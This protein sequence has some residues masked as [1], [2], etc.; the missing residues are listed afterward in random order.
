[1]SLFS[2]D[3]EDEEGEDDDDDDDDS[4]DETAQ[5]MRELE[6]IKA[7]R[8]AASAKK[9]QEEQ[10]ERERREE[11]IARGNPLLNGGADDARTERDVSATPF[12]SDVTTPSFG[13]KRRW[14]DGECLRR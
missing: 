1:M 6:K 13:V 14:D 9:A 12:G 8:A 2:S 4:E 11:Q 3:D 5:L 7:E 10:E